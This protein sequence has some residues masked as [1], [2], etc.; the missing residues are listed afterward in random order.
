MMRACCVWN[1]T[2]Q[3]HVDFQSTF[4]DNPPPDEFATHLDPMLA[5]S[6][7][8]N[9]WRGKALYDARSTGK[10][11]GKSSS[12]RPSSYSPIA[13][14]HCGANHLQMAQRSADARF[15]AHKCSRAGASCRSTFALSASP[16]VPARDT[17]IVNGVSSVG[18][19]L[20]D[21]RSL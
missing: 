21:E 8:P 15:C 1:K 10:E 3:N 2:S 17:A 6:R 11:T 13:P 5:A 12:H 19:M 7:S 16:D 14:G 18:W 9:R 4:R 20:M